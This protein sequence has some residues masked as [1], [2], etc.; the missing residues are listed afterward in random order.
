MMS[1]R[2]NRQGKHGTREQSRAMSVQTVRKLKKQDEAYTRV[3]EDRARRKAQKEEKVA[4]W[5]GQKIVFVD[6]PEEQTQT[7]MSGES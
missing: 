5:Q 4:P 2:S 6:T 7:A 3:M 1:D